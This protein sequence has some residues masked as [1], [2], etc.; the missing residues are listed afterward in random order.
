MTLEQLLEEGGGES[1]HIFIFS[2]YWGGGEKLCSPAKAIIMDNNSFGLA[3]S[4]PTES[5]SLPISL[6]VKIN[7]SNSYCCYC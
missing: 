7:D 4:V 2:K 6:I 1:I 3:P 5:S